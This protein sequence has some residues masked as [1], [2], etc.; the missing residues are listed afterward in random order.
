M[1]P[2]NLSAKGARNLMVR[3]KN[4]IRIFGAHM[5]STQRSLASRCERSAVLAL[6]LVQSETWEEEVKEVLAGAGQ[7]AAAQAAD[8]DWLAASRF[9]VDHCH[10]IRPAL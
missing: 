4:P 7:F 2:R 9:L 3:V 1:T 8:P 6:C 5:T 10:S